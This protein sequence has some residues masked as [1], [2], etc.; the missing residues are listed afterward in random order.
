MAAISDHHTITTKTTCNNKSKI[1]DGKMVFQK[2]NHSR[3]S[4]IKLNQINGLIEERHNS[5]LL[6]VK[7]S[8]F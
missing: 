7:W 4:R 1:Q 6:H 8:N 2:L 5:K 3:I